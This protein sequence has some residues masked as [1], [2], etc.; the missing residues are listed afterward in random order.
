MRHIQEEKLRPAIFPREFSFAR[1]GS[2]FF[3]L[4]KKHEN[5]LR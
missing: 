3:A 2:H 1:E 5:S 4:Q